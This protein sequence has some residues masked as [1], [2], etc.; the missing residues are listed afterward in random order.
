MKKILLVIATIAMTFSMMT[1][2]A[3]SASADDSCSL[4]GTLCGTVRHYSPDD[5]YDDPIAIRCDYGEGP[6]QF[7]Y[8]GQSSTL[9]CK[10]TDEIYI[11]SNEELWCRYVVSG[12]HGDYY[13]WNK[14]FD[15][16]GWHQI[17]N[18]FNRSCRVQRD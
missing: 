17:H 9:R 7:V 8:E 6:T 16:Q 13:V 11:R 10:D 2:G 15:A 3:K 4:F 1:L 14:T 18:D 5:G 12:A